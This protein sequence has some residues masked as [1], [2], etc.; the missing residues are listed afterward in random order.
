MH[1]DSQQVAHQVSY[2]LGALDVAHLAR[3]L[4]FLK[5]LCDGIAKSTVSSQVNNLG[6]LLNVNS[7]R[8]E[9]EPT[10]SLLYQ[11]VVVAE[12]FLGVEHVVLGYELRVA[13]RLSLVGL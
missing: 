2:D 10:Q 12:V 1:K 9:Y 3:S 6:A 11:V 13:C 8:F 7:L 5:H 4:N